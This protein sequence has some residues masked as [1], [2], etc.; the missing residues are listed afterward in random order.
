[1]EPVFSLDTNDLGVIVTL[2]YLVNYKKGTSVK[3]RMQREILSQFNKQE[4]IKF[5]V[6]DIRLLPYE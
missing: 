2:R 6:S 4:D 3:T 1:M 5:A